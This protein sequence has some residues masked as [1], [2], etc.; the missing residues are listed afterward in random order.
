[1]KRWRRRL[2]T[3]VQREMVMR[4]A[5]WCTARIYSIHTPG[6]RA[7]R[8]WVE[9]FWDDALDSFKAYAEKEK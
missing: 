9:G 5:R 4:L 6:L 8:D 1:M 2:F 7:L 3:G